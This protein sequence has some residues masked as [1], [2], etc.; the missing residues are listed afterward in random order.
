MSIRV[1]MVLESLVPQTWGGY[2][3]TYRCTYD[4]KVAEDVSFQKAT[5]NGVIHMT[6]DNPAAIAQMK[7][8]QAYYVDFNEVKAEI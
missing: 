1:K 6:V 3:A 2:Q 5:P 4:S 8:G 7:I